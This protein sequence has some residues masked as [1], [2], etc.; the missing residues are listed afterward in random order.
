[1]STQ[2]AYFETLMNAAVDAIIVIDQNGRI[3]VFNNAAEK[4]FGYEKSQI[5]GEN[6]SRLMP[7]DGVLYLGG[8]ESVLG[9][10]DAFKPIPGLRGIYGVVR[11]Q[12]SG[13]MARKAG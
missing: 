11:D 2:E 6:V 10:S 3:E 12:A 7:E 5:L 13:S 1:M 8:A 9:I 4:I